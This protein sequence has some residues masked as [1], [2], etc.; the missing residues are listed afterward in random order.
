MKRIIATLAVAV[1]AMSAAFSAKA[2]EDQWNKGTM[3]VSGTTSFLPGIG[4]TLSGD[5]VLF[6]T[7]WKGHFTVGGQIGYRYQ[8]F[9]VADKYR[10][11]DLAAAAR[12]T[13]GLNITD[14]FEVHVGLL[15][16]LGDRMWK[17]VTTKNTGDNLGFYSG[18]FVG[19]HF[20]F[21]DSFAATAEVSYINYLFRS[22]LEYYNSHNFGPFFNLGVS[23]KF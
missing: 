5:F 18:S 9:E 23:F 20:F 8:A 16:G 11:N 10:T 15:S 17:D 4:G 1:V 13:Y 12:A 7:W 3:V 19:L 21:T 6:D 14:Q 2:I 22:P